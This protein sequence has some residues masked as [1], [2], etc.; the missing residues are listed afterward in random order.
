MFED[1]PTA[2]GRRVEHTECPSCW[3]GAVL[4][5]NMFVRGQSSV[6]CCRTSEKDLEGLVCYMDDPFREHAQYEMRWAV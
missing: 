3:R 5:P 4:G 6:F 1:A 2:F